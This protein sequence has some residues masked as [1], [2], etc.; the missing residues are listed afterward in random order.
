MQLRLCQ[1]LE[2]IRNECRQIGYKL[3]GYLEYCPQLSLYLKITIYTHPSSAWAI[4]YIFTFTC[5]LFLICSMEVDSVQQ[6]LLYLKARLSSLCCFL[7]P[8]NIREIS[9]LHKLGTIQYL[10]PLSLCYGQPRSRQE[11]R[12]RDSYGRRSE[13]KYIKEWILRVYTYYAISSCSS[14]NTCYF[15]R[16]FL[17]HAFRSTNAIGTASVN[18]WSPTK[19]NPCSLFFMM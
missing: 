6:L 11:G 12:K 19:S 17:S 2:G 13:K 7:A 8:R 9:S 1:R 5:S 18:S 4:L 16:L 10:Q 15:F 3:R 14:H